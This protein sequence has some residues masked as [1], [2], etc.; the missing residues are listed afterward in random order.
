[1]PDT[2]MRAEMKMSRTMFEAAA[3]AYGNRRED[4]GSGNAVVA[5]ILSAFSVWSA[6]C[7]LR[8]SRLQKEGGWLDSIKVA[9][10]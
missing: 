3:K 5:D 6:S 10:V 7:V 9:G 2:A 1:M 8:R 4:E